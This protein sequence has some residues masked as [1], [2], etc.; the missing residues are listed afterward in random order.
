VIPVAGRRSLRSTASS[1]PGRREEIAEGKERDSGVGQR[2]EG[3][4]T[5]GPILSVKGISLPLFS[6]QKL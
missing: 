3:V 4:L 6:L 1:P 5:C 2:G